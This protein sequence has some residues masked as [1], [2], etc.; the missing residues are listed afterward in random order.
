VNDERACALGEIPPWPGPCRRAKDAP[1]NA[2]IHPTQR[3]LAVALVVTL[4]CLPLLV[5]DLLGGH[6]SG[7]SSEAAVVNTDVPEPSLV[8]AV[9]PSEAPT[10]TPSTTVTTEPATTP[11]TTPSTTAPP[12]K[13]GTSASATSVT[14]TPKAAAKVTP[15]TTAAPKVA[16]P[17]A[18]S[19]PTP[20]GSESSTLACIRQRESHGDY[21][22]VDPSGTYRGAYQ[23]Y[24][25]GW[26][27]TARSL[28]RSDL[29]GVRPNNASPADQDMVALQ[30]LRLNGTRPWGGACG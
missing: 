6:S 1:L 15:P 27:A 29:V 4:A 14:T 17:V 20:T 16:A 30:M 10:S 7:T 21:T 5:L 11:S 19:G 12:K 24:Q 25:P 3:R 22:A 23:I 26:D 13:A 8:V 28:G 9:S 2:S 18:P